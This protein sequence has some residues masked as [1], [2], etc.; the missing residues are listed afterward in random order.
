[1]TN[2]FIHDERTDYILQLNYA[3]VMGYRFDVSIYRGRVIGIDGMKTYANHIKKLID[4]KE[5]YHRF[6]YEGKFVVKTIYSL[7]E[8]I[9]MTEYEYKEEVLFVFMNK[10]HTTCTFEVDGHAI[11]LECDD[12]YCMLKSNL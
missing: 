12:V 4:L 10:N 9:I 1:M 5:K 6:F 3:F 11:T 7:P 8:N 2:R